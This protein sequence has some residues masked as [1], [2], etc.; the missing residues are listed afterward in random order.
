[1]EESLVDRA[2]IERFVGEFPAPL[3]L[4]ARNARRV[5]E[6]KNVPFAFIRYGPMPVL[7]S[8][9]PTARPLPCPLLL[10]RRLPGNGGAL[11]KTVAR[12]EDE[13]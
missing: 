9:V 13:R 10:V 2:R 1:M 11:V 12:K 8:S 4:E 7:F 3:V 6:H 5:T